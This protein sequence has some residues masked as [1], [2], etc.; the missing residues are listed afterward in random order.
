MKLQAKVSDRAFSGTN[1]CAD[2]DKRVEDDILSED[3]QNDRFLPG[4]GFGT[5]LTDGTYALADGD[6]C[7]EDDEG[8]VSSEHRD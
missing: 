6:R 8:E 5:G 2:D 1:A 4:G 7:D 3:E